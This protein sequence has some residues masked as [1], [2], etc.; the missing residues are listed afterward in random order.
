MSR[1]PT[2]KFETATKLEKQKQ[3]RG[4]GKRQAP[5]ELK[6]SGLGAASPARRPAGGAGEGGGMR[7][8]ARPLS[9]HNLCS[10]SFLRKVAINRLASYC[11]LWLARLWVAVALWLD[12]KR[13]SGCRTGQ[14]RARAE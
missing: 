12:S 10:R 1:G 13:S 3:G 8:A 14:K 4:E 2:A 5:E 6:R 9:K 11:G 7:G